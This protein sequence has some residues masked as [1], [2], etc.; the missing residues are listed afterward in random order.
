MLYSSELFNNNIAHYPNTIP[1]ALNLTCCFTI[2]ILKNKLNG[3]NTR[4]SV[5]SQEINQG[6]AGAT[7]QRES[8]LAGG[9]ESCGGRGA[10]QGFEAPH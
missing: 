8:A 4:V 1:S 5:A 3:S 10:G 7:Q 9:G 2:M 6:G